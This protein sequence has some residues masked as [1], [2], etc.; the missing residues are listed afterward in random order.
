M[1]YM[2]KALCSNFDIML[3]SDEV[4]F[5]DGT[6]V[7]DLIVSYKPNHQSQMHIQT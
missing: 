3:V 1:L 7:Y 5:G 2:V 6:L 4:K